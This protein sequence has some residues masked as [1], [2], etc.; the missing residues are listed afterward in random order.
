MIDA[1]KGPAAFRG[2]FHM[3]ANTVYKGLIEKLANTHAKI[4]ANGGR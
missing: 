4:H 2:G 3:D 1:L